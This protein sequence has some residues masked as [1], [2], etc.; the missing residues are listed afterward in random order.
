ML[1]TSGRDGGGVAVNPVFAATR[2]LL[3]LLQLYLHSDHEVLY[4]LGAHLL[5]PVH[6]QFR[7]R[8]CASIKF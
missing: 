7:V 1:H 5:D 4:S 6:A 8:V 2:V 3:L